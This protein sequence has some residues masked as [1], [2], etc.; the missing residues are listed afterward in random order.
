[1]PKMVNLASF[2]KTEARGQTVLTDRSTLIEHKL[3]KIAKIE[4]YKWD[5]LSDLQTMW[6][7]TSYEGFLLIVQCSVFITDGR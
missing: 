5:V 7:M 3:L 4:K 1:M 2:W 6:M